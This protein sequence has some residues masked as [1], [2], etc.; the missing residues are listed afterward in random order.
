[1]FWVGRAKPQLDRGRASSGKFVV[2]SAATVSAGASVLDPCTPPVE[3]LSPVFAPGDNSYPLINYEY[4]LV[5]KRQADPDKAAAL[6]QPLPWAVSLEGGNAP[7][8]LDAVGF[9]PLP[10]VIRALSENQINSIE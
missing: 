8:C 4:A 10:D 6:P 7:T 9:I 3:R 5:S 1:M 2:P